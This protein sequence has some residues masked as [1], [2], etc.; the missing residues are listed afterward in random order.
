[1]D[2]TLN[3]LE[4]HDRPLDQGVTPVSY[5]SESFHTPPS[6]PMTGTM[7]PPVPS[8]SIGSIRRQLKQKDGLK[9]DRSVK[10]RKSSS[11][12]S[13]S[14]VSTVRLEKRTKSVTDSAAES[15]DDL[16]DSRSEFN[17]SELHK[18]DVEMDKSEHPFS[19]NFG[20]N[21][22]HASDFIKRMLEQ[23]L[24]NNPPVYDVNQQGFS[25]APPTEDVNEPAKTSNVWFDD[26]GCM[27]ATVGS[28][29]KEDGSSYD[30]GKDKD[31]GDKEFWENMNDFDGN[32]KG[33]NT[34]NANTGNVWKRGTTFAEMIKK[35]ASEEEI[36]L[37]FIPPK[38]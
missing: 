11:K 2:S 28:E 13:M 4:N 24:K 8:Q 30:E 22:E 35:S 16:L 25:Y 20:N 36:K 7:P 37:E 17:D 27:H 34:S 33:A 38:P 32:T 26:N 15:G 1:M 5:N 9:V 23:K 18:S 31:K 21:A 19:G 3:P 6:V 14:S 10:K 12:K 29:T